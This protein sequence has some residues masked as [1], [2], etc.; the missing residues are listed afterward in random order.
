[1]H[2]HDDSVDDAIDSVDS[3]APIELRNASVNAV[4]FAQRIITIVAVPYEQPAL[5]P[6]KGDVWSE[7]FERGSFASVQRSPQRVRANRDHNRSRTV[8]KVVKFWPDQPDSEGLVAEVR[9][10]QT[11]LGDETLALADED[12]VSA[13]IGFGARSSDQILDRMTKTRR[14]KSAYLDHLAFVESPAYV[15]ANV[16][17]VRHD[18]ELIV[19][20]EQQTRARTP[21]LDAFIAEADILRWAAQRLNKQ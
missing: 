10:A 2:E 9:I 20:A 6:F 21:N 1:M 17:S 13:S 3:R 14:I 19:R 11:P 15:G 8:G 12:C 4:N 7:V 5:V 18:D 16:L